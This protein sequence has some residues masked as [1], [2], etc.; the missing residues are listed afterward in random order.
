MLRPS[1]APGRTGPVQPRFDVLDDV[2]LLREVGL[3]AGDPPLLGRLV[4]EGQQ[5]PDASMTPDF[6]RTHAECQYRFLRAVAEGRPAKP[7]LADGL[8][9]QAVMAAAE[10]SSAGGGWVQVEEDEHA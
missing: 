8:H 10:R 4:R 7:D 1:A 5:A 6:V 2:E 3:G 9:I